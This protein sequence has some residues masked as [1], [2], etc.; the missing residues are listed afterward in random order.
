MPDIQGSRVQGTSW[1]KFAAKPNLGWNV[2]VAWRHTRERIGGV[3][4]LVESYS[5][6]DQN[7][8][9]RETTTI[10]SVW[11][12]CPEGLHLRKCAAIAQIVG[13]YQ[14]RVTIQKDDQSEDAASV[15]GLMTLAASEGT[16]LTLS[17]TGVDA[18]QAVRAIAALLD[19]D[20]EEPQATH[21]PWHPRVPR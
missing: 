6:A 15:L 18:E 11:V 19:S 7:R 4:L 16:Q 10:R 14:A 1:E 20:V 5:P 13:K 21:S 12:N 17:A 9:D 3:R 8:E 2:P